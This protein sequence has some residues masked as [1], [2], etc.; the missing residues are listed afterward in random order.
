MGSGGNP[1]PAGSMVGGYE[2]SSMNPGGPGAPR[3]RRQLGNSETSPL[4][5]LGSGGAGA[6]A[7]AGGFMG[8]ST[9][10]GSPLGGPLG[11]MLG[12][13]GRPGA[14]PKKVRSSSKHGGRVACGTTGICLCAQTPPAPHTAPGTHSP[15]V[16]ACFLHQG[17]R[18]APCMTT[19]DCGCRCAH[20]R[21]RACV[22]GEGE[23]QPH[24]GRVFTCDAGWAQV[25]GGGGAGEDG[26]SHGRS[27]GAQAGGTGGILRGPYSLPGAGG[28]R[29]CRSN[30]LAGRRQ[31]GGREG[32]GAACPC[33]PWRQSSL[34]HAGTWPTMHA[35]HSWRI[36]RLTVLEPACFDAANVVCSPG[37]ELSVAVPNPAG[38][39]PAQRPPALQQSPTFGRNL[40]LSSSDDVRPRVWPHIHACAHAHTHT[41]THTH[42]Q[43]ACMVRM[44]AAED[45]QQHHHTVQC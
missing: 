38:A 31:A 35:V 8:G 21:L 16:Y 15:W 5:G 9:S 24:C 39:P 13:G 1:S 26:C 40:G 43:H 28:T 7:A 2:P 30:R 11:G 29:C 6:G 20:L 32:R 41:H 45:H 19:H 22:W 10:S 17:A 27:H 12:G 34:G 44:A 4:S 33:C 25:Q 42:T 37:S 14:L 36:A 23:V 18:G 3:P